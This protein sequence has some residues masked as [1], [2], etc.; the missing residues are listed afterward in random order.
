MPSPSKASLWV[1][2][3][4]L[5]TSAGQ[6]DAGNPS[7]ES[8]SFSY[9]AADDL[10]NLGNKVRVRN[11]F[12]VYQ[13]DLP[14]L[15]IPQNLKAVAQPN[16]GVALEW[17][18]VEEARYV[19]YRRAES[20]TEFT[21]LA[22]LSE[23]QTTDQLPSDGQYYYAIAS[24]RRSN[25]QI[26]VS[27]LSAPVA[28]SAD[29]IA[30]AAPA[31]LAL[32]L[33]GAGIVATWSAPS[34][35]AE[36]NTEE[37]AALTYNLYRLGVGEGVNV[38]AEELQNVIPLQTGIPEPIALDANPSESQHAYAITA[39]DEAGNESAPSDTAYLNFGLLPVSDLS[40][41]INADGSPQL[42]WQH[43]GA[44]IAG[45]RVYVGGTGEVGEGAENLQ[46]I[47]SAL[48][49]HSSNPTTFVDEGFTAGAQGVTAERRYTVIAEDDQGA[50]SIGHSLLLPALSVAVI[51]PADGQSVLERG[52]MNEVRFRVQNRGS[53]DVAGLKLFATVSDNGT[54]REHQSASFSVAAGGIVEV[55]IVIGGYAK[56]D[57]L[58]D[59]QLRLEQ[60]PLPG[61]TVFIHAQDQVMVGDAALRLSLESDTVYRGGLGKFRF[62]LENTSLVE[63]E[64]LM[65]RNNG[66]TA[67]DEIRIRLEDA[68]GNLLTLQDVQQYTG[69]VITVA[70]G[71]TVARLQPGESFVSDWIEVPV[72]AAAPDLVTVALE[73]DHFRYHTGKTTEV[74]IDGNGTRTQA[75]CRRPPTTAPWIASPLRRSTPPKTP[76]P[77]PARPSTG[78]ATPPPAMSR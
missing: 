78:T 41:T 18:P 20:D 70:S 35:D 69:D 42:Q 50:T 22:R 53:A 54:N 11:A 25:D 68:D 64:L 60:S 16:A 23:T 3:F 21:E 55:P 14:P 38:T 36:G 8:L 1:G 5:P 17:D 66:K 19:L 73:V 37:G 77:S 24:E 27:A 45:Y 49:P 4:T 46:E 10:D 71:A 76:S 32:E 29:S 13:G 74:I 59:I 26:A 61:E 62:T 52:V 7:V 30:P 31:D 47:T 40:I 33:N 28:V 51:E 15:D 56:L 43:S 63:T 48:I 44:A 39:L 72:P 65:A 9:Q 58:S 57:T 34:V 67:S 6:D 12:Q 75:S 2:S